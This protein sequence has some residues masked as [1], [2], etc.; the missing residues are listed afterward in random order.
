MYLKRSLKS[1]IL[2]GIVFFVLSGCGEVRQPK[3]AQFNSGVAKTKS[4]ENYN[5]YA[6]ENNQVSLD[7]VA[8]TLKC[9]FKKKVLSYDNF[10][11]TDP[12]VTLQTKWHNCKPSDLM[13]FKF[14]MP[15]GRLYHYSKF[16]MKKVYK[17]YSL[18]RSIFIKNLPPSR[19]Q[20]VWKVDIFANGKFVMS[21]KFSIGDKNKSYKKAK[22][23]LTIGIL[24]FIDDAE[25]STWKHY[26]GITNYLTYS[27]LENYKSV[28]V[29]SPWLLFKDLPNVAIDYK[30][31]KKYILE[32][33]S[34]S[35]SI[36]LGLAKKY[37]LDY[38]LLGRTQSYW[39]N[40][41]HNTKVDIYIVD[42]KEGKIIDEISSV[43]RLYRSDWNI[44]SQ[45]RVRGMHPKR[46][47]VYE[48]IFEDFDIKFKSIL[49]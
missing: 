7:F 47:K 22:T 42:A 41:S 39:Y 38:V 49:K 12:M 43:G 25:M 24:P 18:C 31:F 35:D 5:K 17:K 23:N 9:D 14:Y 20:G 33:L 19:I 29:I 16:E 21:K 13:E 26:R 45:Q 37:S 44:A 30:G 27:I 32:D 11:I 40:S 3:V 10:L 28:K 34:S 1:F 4:W 6:K 15:D 46:L 8:T 48:E 36:L 2:L